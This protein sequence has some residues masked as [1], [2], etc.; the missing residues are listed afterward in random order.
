M[1]ERRTSLPDID[2]DVESAPRLKLYDRIFER[3]GR[4]RVTVTGMPETYRARHALRDTGL[5]LGIAPGAVDEIAK[6]FPHIRAGAIRSALAELPELRKLAAR[7]QEYG[8]LFEL[9]EGLDALVHGYAMHQ[10][11]VILSDATLPDRLPV[12]PT[13]GGADPMLQADTEDVEDLGLLKLDVLGVRIQS[14]MAHAVAEIRRITGRHR[15]LDL[16][17]PDHVD[18]RTRRRSR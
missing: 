2:L 7:A 16:D 4:A 13:P 8:P 1:S 17:N 10:G 3:F 12:Q 11:G 18:L 5:A 14:A 15:D 6:S 9:A